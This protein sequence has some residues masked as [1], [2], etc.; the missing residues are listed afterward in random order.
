MCFCFFGIAECC[1]GK[2]LG[3]KAVAEYFAGDNRDFFFSG[4]LVKMMEVDFAA[5]AGG[6]A[7]IVSESAPH[8]RFLFDG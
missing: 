4:V 8:W 3:D 5:S 6:N 1:D 7:Q 2:F